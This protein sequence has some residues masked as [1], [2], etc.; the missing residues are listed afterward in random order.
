[1]GYGKSDETDRLFNLD[2]RL[3]NLM[4]GPSDTY[5]G[6]LGY[7]EKARTYPQAASALA[8]RLAEKARLRDAKTI[9][10][11]GFGCGDQIHCGWRHSGLN[12]LW[13][14]IFLPNKLSLRTKGLKNQFVKEEFN[15]TWTVTS[16]SI[17]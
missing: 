9:V 2:E 3:L 15:C 12:L 1:M 11:I 16:T 17:S 4:D 7:W 8:M 14:S 10:D 6:N 5:W 13:E